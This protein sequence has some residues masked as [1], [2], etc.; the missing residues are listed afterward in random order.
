MSVTAILTAMSISTRAFL[1][2]FPACRQQAERGES[3]V[4]ESR[5]G[6]KF[7]LHRIGDTPRPRRVL[8]PLSREIT[9]GSSVDG[10]AFDPGE[11]RMDR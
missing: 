9:D 6:V 8:T 1:R 2:G 7:V 3:V 11:W 10:P 5:E 4:I